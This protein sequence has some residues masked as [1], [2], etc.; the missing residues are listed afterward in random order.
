MSSA[1]ETVVVVSGGGL[2]AQGV[3]INALD[4]SRQKRLISE[5]K[6]EPGLSVKFI[7]EQFID[8]GDV[9]PLELDLY[10]VF[11]VRCSDKDAFQR[12]MQVI[13]SM[14]RS[15]G[16][17]ADSAGSRTSRARRVRRTD[18]GPRPRY[19]QGVR[20]P[21]YV[22]LSFDARSGGR[23]TIGRPTAAEPCGATLLI[24]R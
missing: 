20:E 5:L 18:R 12:A 10:R 16:S 15:D 14:R 23:Y 8:R 22:R 17:G 11:D 4:Q 7:G 21:C 1:V 19:A 2:N 9:N 6:R 13:R 3:K 24:T